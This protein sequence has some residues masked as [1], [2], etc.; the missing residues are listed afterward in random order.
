MLFIP[1]YEEGEGRMREILAARDVPANVE[2]AVERIRE[3]VGR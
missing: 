3:L 2:A 1:V